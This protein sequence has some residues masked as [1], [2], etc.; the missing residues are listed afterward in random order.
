MW[1]KKFYILLICAV[2]VSYS[3]ATVETIYFDDFS[4]SGSTELHG[5][6]PDIDNNG[7][8]NTWIAHSS[9]KADGTAG[10][11]SSATIPFTPTSGYLY[12]LTVTMRDVIGDDYWLALGYAAGS[13][14]QEGGNGTRFID[15]PTSGQPWMLRRG[16]NA[17]AFDQ[18]FLGPGTNN[19]QAFE[20]LDRSEDI[21][22]RM[23]VDARNTNWKAYW[24]HKLVS[25]SYYQPIRSW[26]YSTNPSIA[27]VG[28]ACGESPDHITGRFENFILERI[29][30]SLAIT[31][32]GNPEDVTVYEGIT[33][34]FY[35]KCTSDST[36]VA[37]WH[38]IVDT[39]DNI[40][41]GNDPD[42]DIVLDYNSQTEVYTSILSIANT[43]PDDEGWYYCVLNNDDDFPVIST[44]AYL[45]TGSFVSYWPLD[46]DEYQDGNYLD[47]HSAHNA[48]V[49]GT[50][51]FVDGVSGI[52]DTAVEIT[53]Q[54][55]WA[56]SGDFELTSTDEFSI[57]VWGNWYGGDANALI[58]IT[59][60]SGTTNLGAVENSIDRWR[61][62]CITYDGLQGRMYLDGQKVYEE[63]WPVVELG[64]LN[65]Q[66]GHNNGNEFF[67]GAIDEIKLYDLALSDSQ[68]GALYTRSSDCILSYADGVDVAGPYGV[69]DCLIN[70]YDYTAVTDLEHLAELAE[71]WLSCGLYP[72]CD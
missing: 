26:Q 17:T 5:L 36:P 3:S 28:L 52:E 10:S 64:N 6:S 67:N 51:V 66:I 57:S 41:D 68:V 12:Q 46:A 20:P 61:H 8:S 19:G 49:T 34:Y 45:D 38:H 54:N 43:N 60:L 56:T 32:D 14:I 48:L 62:L 63:Y 35:V 25:Q 37:T 30:T 13:S 71:G 22:F 55:G 33:A 15:S 58:I 44:Q 1:L 7:G 59:A 50:P 53:P 29:Q 16:N 2:A 24:Y 42:I 23:I 21:N 39:Q 27:A 11:H 69:P 70:F 9:W 18:L 4:G 40:V 47:I 65:V 72:D 31:E